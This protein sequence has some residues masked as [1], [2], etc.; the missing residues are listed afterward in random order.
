MTCDPIWQVTLRSFAMGFSCTVMHSFN[1]LIVL[2]YCAV[3]RCSGQYAV[4][5]VQSADGSELLR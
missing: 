4:N 2:L 3:E 5:A 1:P